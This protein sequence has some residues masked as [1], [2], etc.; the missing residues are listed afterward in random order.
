MNE[1]TSSW[2]TIGG[3]ALMLIALFPGWSSISIGPIT[4]SGDSPFNY[5]FTGGIAWLLCVAVGVLALLKQLGKLGGAQNWAMIFTAAAGLAA[6]LMLIR[7]IMGGRSELGISLDRGAGMYIGFVAALVTAAGATMGFL[8]GGGS[9]S[10]LKDV[11]K[12]K[13]A[14]DDDPDT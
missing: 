13:G 11:D 4:E 9:L 3:G 5:F 12:L 1:Q 8:A 10:D 6:L 14:I 7:I 2:I